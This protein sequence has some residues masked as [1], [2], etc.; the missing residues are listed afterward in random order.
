MIDVA[1]F[2]RWE[3]WWTHPAAGMTFAWW[4]YKCWK[5]RW[6]HTSFELNLRYRCWWF[7]DKIYC[8]W[9]CNFACGFYRRSVTVLACFWRGISTPVVVAVFDV[10][11]TLIGRMI[12]D[13][14]VDDMINDWKTFNA[15]WM[16]FDVIFI[17]IIHSLFY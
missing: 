3:H 7:D 5:V 8:C 17:I 16:M 13:D 1:M 11:G 4:N 6:Y 15:H 2:T 14:V 10:V 9:Y 12:D